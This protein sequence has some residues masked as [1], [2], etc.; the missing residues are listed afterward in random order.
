MMT[1]LDSFGCKQY[2]EATM[3]GL[4]SK[5]DTLTKHLAEQTER[6]DY[7]WKN[8]NV[9]EKARQEL[10]DQIVDW[11][12]KASALEAK[13]QIAV[14]ALVTIKFSVHRVV[15]NMAESALAKIKEMK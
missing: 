14:E 5:I 9:L 11:M 1:T 3:N 13:L 7:A 2:E 4:Q 8:T 6:A 12:Q 10:A 15:A